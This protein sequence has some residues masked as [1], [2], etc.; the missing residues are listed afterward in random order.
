MSL[1]GRSRLII[2]VITLLAL[3]AIGC[4]RI[5]LAKGYPQTEG[6]IAGLPVTEPVQVIRDQWGIPHIFANNRKDL[7]VALGLVHA[8]DRLWQMETLR[9]IA[10]G[11]LSEVAGEE[12]LALDHWARLIGLPEICRSLAGKIGKE[13]RLI[14]EA[15]LTGINA[16]IKQQGDDLPLEF[17]KLGITP[18]PWTLEDIFAIPATNAWFLQTNFAQEWL[19]LAGRK[20]LSAETIKDLLPSYP[21]AVLPDDTHFENLRGLKIGEL[22]PAM[23]SLYQMLPAIDSRGSNNWVTADGPGGK[24]LLAGD[25]HLELI[26][27]AV[28]YFCHL[29]LPDWQA[30][31]ATMA[32]VPGI[33]IGHNEHIAWSLTNVMADITDLFV[34]RLDPNQPD[35]YLAGD[36]SLPFEISEQSYNLPDN[37]VVKK[38]IR[39]TIHGPVI[40]EL[41]EG[42]D[43]V[44]AL[45]WLGSVPM[46]QIKD[47]SGRAIEALN[48]A[49][50]VTDAFAACA[51]FKLGT[52]NLVV[53]DVQ[54]NIGWQVF[55]AIPVRQGYSGR[56]PADGSTGEMDW[57]GFIEYDQLPSSLN[58]KQ[59]W[60]ATANNRTTTDDYPYTLTHDWCPPYRVDRIGQHLKN[61]QQPTIKDFQGMQADVFSRQA[62][63]IIPKLAAFSFTDPKAQ[64]AASMLSGWDMNVSA[65]SAGAAVWEVFL[66]RF[67]KELLADELGESL[68]WIYRLFAASYLAHD[69]IFDRPDSALW[70]R[71]DTDQKETPQQITEA[72]L[73]G[74]YLW[75]EERLGPDDS[76]W[77]WG[78]IHR[79]FWAHPG[80][81][82]SYEHWLMSKGPYPAPGD[83][84]TMNLAGY[85]AGNDKYDVFIIPSLRMIAPLDDLTKT[86]IVG[87]MGQSAQPGHPHY[88]DLLP[89]WLEG[90]QIPLLFDKEEIERQAAERLVLTP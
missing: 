45:K 38:Q 64:K 27:P 10:T 48:R 42:T 3:T 62:E 80:A 25:P 58:P 12:T 1:S 84:I 66:V 43:A 89:H 63:K 17:N 85:D 73:S 71:I 35:H 87:P 7:A 78:K 9:R 83:N 34:F 55:G 29:S 70:D 49:K 50:S 60:I 26:V 41:D 81:R 65:D 32:G 79:Y 53:G 31:G 15:Y 24:P 82:K 90:K 75:L 67:A 61:L 33:I 51:M 16:Y 69:V 20:H 6:T 74:A 46:E 21:G 11:R 39:R 44:V 40:T 86:M 36:R 54:G 72:A 22:L 18:E 4:Q 59:G 2:V 68:R 47:D 8:Q 52:Q 88:D 13:E 14:A 19:A 5:F 76:K 30:A 37:R 28:W 57:T 56:L 23:E 77:Q